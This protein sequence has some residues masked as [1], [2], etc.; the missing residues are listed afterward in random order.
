MKREAFSPPFSRGET[1]G[2]LCPDG[3]KAMGGH[4][5]AITPARKTRM[6]LTNSLN[7]GAATGV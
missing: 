5:P 6:N 4:D 7:P 3:H 1:G 2:I